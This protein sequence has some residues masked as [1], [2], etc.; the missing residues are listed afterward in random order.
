MA[1]KVKKMCKWDKSRIGK[2]FDEFSNMVRNPTH[3]C[4]K[5]CRVSNN[6]KTLCKPK[7]L[8]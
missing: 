1:D 8:T 7:S 5:C 2:N 3:A 6:K 4:T